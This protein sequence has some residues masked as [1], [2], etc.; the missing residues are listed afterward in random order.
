LFVAALKNVAQTEA[1]KS[2][3]YHFISGYNVAIK[4][5]SHHA[6]ALMLLRNSEI[7]RQK[8][9]EGRTGGY[10]DL[11]EESVARRN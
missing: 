5:K 1:S 2:A 11:F 6:S 10:I 9:Q 8:K 4:S 7:A 3:I